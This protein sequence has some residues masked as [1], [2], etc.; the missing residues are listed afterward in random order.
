VVGHVREQVEMADHGPATRRRWQPPR[1]A[2]RHEVEVDS[3]EDEQGNGRIRDKVELHGES[4]CWPSSV[5]VQEA[6]SK[7]RLLP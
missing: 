4:S 6:I 5:Q 7:G 2:P 3:G 1:R